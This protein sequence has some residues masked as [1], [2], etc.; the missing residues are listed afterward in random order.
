MMTVM[1]ALAIML[2]PW[3][4]AR[5]DGLRVAIP[6]AALAVLA[7]SVGARFGA[8]RLIPLPA[9]L[10]AFIARGI[11]RMPSTAGARGRRAPSVSRRSPFL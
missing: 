8:S 7:A 3:M 10:D 11:S 2:H 5:I 1:A 6:L 4:K 9:F